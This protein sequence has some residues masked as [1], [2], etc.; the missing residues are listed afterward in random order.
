MIDALH[1]GQLL[2]NLKELN[3]TDLISNKAQKLKEEMINSRP[4]FNQVRIPELKEESKKLSHII[5]PK[6]H[7]NTKAFLNLKP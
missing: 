1:L 7:L 3:E 2:I 6:F 4:K 5:T